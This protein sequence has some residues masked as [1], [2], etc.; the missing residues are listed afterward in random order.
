MTP[1]FDTDA[2]PLA[3]GP[4]PCLP[5]RTDDGDESSWGCECALPYLQGMA[6]SMES[7]TDA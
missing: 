7:G 2:D 4:P 5:P 1:P 6:G 3:A